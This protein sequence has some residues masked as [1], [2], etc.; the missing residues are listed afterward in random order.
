[1]PTLFT[2]QVFTEAASYICLN[3]GEILENKPTIKVLPI[4]GKSLKVLGQRLKK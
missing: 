2:K 3:V 1:M 4:A